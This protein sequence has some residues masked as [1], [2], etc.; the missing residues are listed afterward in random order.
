M[1]GVA[2]GKR[3]CPPQMGCAQLV[4]CVYLSSA[5]RLRFATS[6]TFCAR[7]ASQTAAL[8]AFPRAGFS[9]TAC[10]VASRYTFSSAA[11]RAFPALRYCHLKLSIVDV[12]TYV[13]VPLASKSA[14][15]WRTHA[16]LAGLKNNACASF[17]P[18]S[19][20]FMAFPRFRFLL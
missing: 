5:S 7:C 20:R 2:V 4:R 18:G 17:L 12:P 8:S 13:G 6:I 10:H 9:R 14:L 16:I 1:G 19:Y 11:S 3:N 15:R